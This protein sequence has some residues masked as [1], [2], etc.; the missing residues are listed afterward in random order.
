MIKIV[1]KDGEH[2]SGTQQIGYFPE[3]VFWRIKLVKSLL[4]EGEPLEKI[5]KQFGRNPATDD[6]FSDSAQGGQIDITEDFLIEEAPALDTEKASQTENQSNQTHENMSF[7]D[8]NERRQNL[9][10]SSRKG[11]FKLTITNM[12]F[13]AYL[14]NHN[15]EVEWINQ[16]AEELLFNVSVSSIQDVKSRNIFKLFLSSEFKLNLKNWKEIIAFHMPYVQDR[17][18]KDM[19]PELFQGIAESEVQFLET[20][21]KQDGA[22]KAS[23]SNTPVQLDLKDGT[24]EYFQVCSIRFR[25]GDFL[26]YIPADQQSHEI[27]EYL[28]KRELV[29]HDLLKHRMPALVSLCVLV[30]DLQDSVKISAELLPGEYFAFINN[31]W[32]SLAGCFEKYGGIYGKHA[33]DGMVYYFIQQPGT[34]YIINAIDCAL[35]LRTRMKEFSSRWKI[36]KGWM[37]DMYLNIGINEGQEFFGTIRSAPNIEFT[38]LGDSINSA[39]RLSDFARFGEIWTTKTVIGKI[40]SDVLENIQFGVNRTINGRNLFT[41]NSFSRIIDLIKRD[42]QNY[43]KFIDIANLPITQI[44]EKKPTGKG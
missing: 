15:L 1:K 23:V 31:L 7:Q 41:Q 14:I 36:K 2:E 11:D 3:S 13:P 32:D 19:L 4:R 28:S 44:I 35:E 38:A 10:F 42:D 27:M 40:N 16:K 18:K 30:A 25:E 34:D 33:G 20:F 21:Y 37:D 8:E 26:V 6:L 43:S 24:V 39:G 29:I 9:S 12:D 5:A 22:I 17:F